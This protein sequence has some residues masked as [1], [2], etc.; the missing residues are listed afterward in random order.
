LISSQINIS[1]LGA[2]GYS[3]AE[4]F[5]ILSHRDDI[6]I[7]QVIANSSVG[8][9]VDEVYPEFAGRIDAV[10]EPLE[11]LRTDSLDCVFIALPS[12][13]AMNIVP[14]LYD[15]VERI[16]DLGGDFRFPSPQIY[17]QYYKHKHTAPQL[18]HEAVYGLPEL[19]KERIANAKLIANPGCY[20]TSTILALAPLLKQNIISPNGIVINS[21]SG[22]SGA[23]RSAALELTFSEVN[24]NIRAYKI[25]T[26]QHNPEI[27]YILE[28]VA[29]QPVSFSFVP[30]LVPMT[31][32]IYSTIYADLN[33]GIAE[34]DI[35]LCFQEF[36]AEA[37]FVRIKNSIP[38]P[39]GRIPEIKDVVYTNFCDIACT[40]DKQAKKLII[41]SVIDNLVKGAAGQAIQ[42]MNIMFGLPEEKG[43]LQKLQ[44]SESYIEEEILSTKP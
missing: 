27:K 32:G 15:N 7:R 29:H 1:V 31:R 39:K 34:E 43:L 24:E 20:P 19:N 12:G 41:I 5:R 22:T 4:L 37:P 10:F 23:G 6:T 25:G 9:R 35:H 33:G 36:Y 16:I 14:S 26:H 17:E 44:V 42:N 3:G 13:E 40:I 11:A 38:L 28:T 18:L 30:H 2:S 21:L 8:K